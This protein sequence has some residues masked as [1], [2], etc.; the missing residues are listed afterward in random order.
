VEQVDALRQEDPLEL[1]RR[2]RRLIDIQ[3]SRSAWACNITQSRAS[4]VENLSRSR[5][6]ARWSRRQFDAIAETS[7]FADH[8]ARS[9]L[10]GLFADGWPAFLVPDALVE[11][12]PDQPAQPVGDG[13]DR[14]GVPPRGTLPSAGSLER[15]AISGNVRPF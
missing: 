11:N 4:R 6:V 9:H 15:S 14:L 12:L 13:A 7:Q 8:L 2:H 1:V 10:F 5:R 3:W